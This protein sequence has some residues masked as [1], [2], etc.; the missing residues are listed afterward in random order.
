LLKY[1]H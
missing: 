1:F